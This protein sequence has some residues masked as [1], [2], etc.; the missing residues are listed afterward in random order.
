MFCVCIQKTGA[1][2]EKSGDFNS[3]AYRIR[4]F[5]K[6]AYRTNVLYPYHYK[7]GY[8]T[9]VPYFLAKIEAYSTVPTY[10]TVLLSLQ[11]ICSGSGSPPIEIPSLMI[12][13]LQKS[14]LFPQFPLASSRTTVI[15][16]IDPESP[17]PPRF[18]FCLPI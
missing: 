18:N 15:N 4:T 11:R 10:H 1:M 13:M 12:K 2:C 16:N 9:S 7:K 5:T 14:L 17:G 3:R 8:R 6:K